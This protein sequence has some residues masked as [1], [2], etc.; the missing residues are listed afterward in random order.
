MIKFVILFLVCVFIIYCTLG[1]CKSAQHSSY[2]ERNHFDDDEKYS[3]DIHN[4]MVPCCRNF[5]FSE[6]EDQCSWMHFC[7]G[8]QENVIYFAEYFDEEGSEISLDVEEKINENSDNN[9]TADFSVISDSTSEEATLNSADPTNIHVEQLKNHYHG[10]ETN[11]SNLKV[12]NN[13]IVS[14]RLMT[15]ESYAVVELD[16]LSQFGPE[17]EEIPLEKLE[18]LCGNNS[19]DVISEIHKLYGEG[20]INED[21]YSNNN[22]NGFNSTISEVLLDYAKPHFNPGE[23]LVQ[24]EEEAH[25]TLNSDDSNVTED[26][27]EDVINMLPQVHVNTHINIH[28]PSVEEVMQKFLKNFITEGSSILR[29]ATRAFKPLL[30]KVLGYIYDVKDA[31]R[32]SCTSSCT[33][34]WMARNVES[35]MNNVRSD[36]IP[37]PCPM[38]VIHV[39]MHELLPPHLVQVVDISSVAE[40]ARDLMDLDTFEHCEYEDLILV[41]IFRKAVDYLIAKSSNVVDLKLV[42]FPQLQ[43]ERYA[44]KVVLAKERKSRNSLGLIV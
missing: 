35:K 10:S 2:L 28:E 26:M 15:S 43:L 23:L 5:L 16:A 1:E 18:K 6:F 24:E 34:S 37:Y 32:T 4:A 12:R 27:K 19:Y 22:N 8:F 29:T 7:Q 38:P 42:E 33:C 21:S 39:H 25:I 31:L 20:N 14:D 13:E 9:L 44:S 41:G 40:E 17:E 30:A 3:L 11:N 36:W